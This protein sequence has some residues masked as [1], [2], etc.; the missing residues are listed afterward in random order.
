MV[1]YALELGGLRPGLL[2]WLRALKRLRVPLL[3]LPFGGGRGD[4]RAGV[5]FPPPSHP[6]V[7]AH[8]RERPAPPWR[9]EPAPAA[10]HR[11]DRR[12]SVHAHT[13]GYLASEDSDERGDE[14]AESSHSSRA[15][16]SF[17]TSQGP[18]GARQRIAGPH[19]NQRTRP[20]IPWDLWERKAGPVDLIPRQ[21]SLRCLG[22][23][24]RSPRPSPGSSR[25][26]PAARSR[27]SGAGPGSGFPAGTSHVP[28]RPRSP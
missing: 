3:R 24:R 9:H 1:M 11:V 2:P 14:V 4:L 17:L 10:G 12:R 28:I 15:G 8:Q 13:L 20:P 19:P 6:D 26:P 21:A 25:R 5:G 27:R 22:F 16:S 18:C 23:P 7:S